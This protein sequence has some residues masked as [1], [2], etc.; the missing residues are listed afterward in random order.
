MERQYIKIKDL[1]IGDI[2]YINIASIGMDLYGD[3]WV[4][5]E[6]DIRHA[7]SGDYHVRIRRNESSVFVD[8]RTVS[9][10]RMIVVRPEVRPDLIVGAFAEF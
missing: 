8:K 9:T 1:R 10:L 7:P 2:A 6:M 3:P 5:E 4:N